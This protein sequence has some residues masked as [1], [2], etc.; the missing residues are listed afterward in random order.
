M[1]KSIEEFRDFMARKPLPTEEAA[2]LFLYEKLKDNHAQESGEFLEAAVDLA[3][4]SWGLQSALNLLSRI[5]VAL[6][7]RKPS[8]GLYDNALHF[9]GGAQKYGCTLA[10]ALRETYDITLLANA[11]VS[12]EQ[13]QSWYNL[14]LNGCRIKIVHIPFFEQK[15]EKK[16]VFDAGRVDLKGDNPFHAVSLESGLYDV[17]VN[18]SMLEMVYPLAPVSEMVVHFPEREISRFF[19]A[20]RYTH[21]IHNSLY[22]AD[23]ISKR[24]QLEP[25]VHIYPPVDMVSPFPA[26]LE[27]KESIILSVARFEPG[28]NKQ[29][30][31]MIK[32]FVSLKRSFPQEMRGWKLVLAGGSTP[33]NPYLTRIKTLVRDAAGHNVE[34][35]VNIPAEQLQDVYR[36]TKIFWHFSGLGQR[37]PARIEH[38][39]MTTVEAMQNACVP[40]VFRGGGQVE[41]VSDQESGYLFSSLREALDKTL[42]VMADPDRTREMAG[43]AYER[44]MEFRKEVFLEKIR[45]HFSGILDRYCFKTESA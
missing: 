22:T 4:Q 8:L 37:D 44:G 29:Q 21:I 12:L 3:T 34:L 30:L 23:W 43:K 17:F 7:Y 28:G 1:S 14:D 20:D 10:H 18:N 40:V 9:I 2:A 19:H 16:G 36:K 25:H 5:E 31:E 27:H 13:L 26:N 42:A 33:E 35:L 39:G 41:I 6:N 45:I 15:I 11:E 38:F 24:W 32:S